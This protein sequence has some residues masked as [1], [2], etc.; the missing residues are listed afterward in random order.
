MLVQLVYWRGIEPS[1]RQQWMDLWSDADAGELLQ[2][3]LAHHTSQ[4]AVSA[5]Y[6]AHRA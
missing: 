6:H 1:R 5:A 3:L 4:Q 2:A